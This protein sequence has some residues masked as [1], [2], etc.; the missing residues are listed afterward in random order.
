M[1]RRKRNACLLVLL[2]LARRQWLRVCVVVLR[3][4][5]NRTWGINQSYRR[6]MACLRVREDVIVE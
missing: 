1:M 4:G 6:D 5:A 3:Q 2:G